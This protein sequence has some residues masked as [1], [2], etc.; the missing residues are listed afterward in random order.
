MIDAYRELFLKPHTTTFTMAG[1]IARIALPMSSIGII[2]MIS[3]LYDSYALAGL[4]SATFVLTYALISPQVSRLV[5]R[6]GQRDILPIVTIICTVGFV[7]LIYSAWKQTGNWCLFIGAFLA[8][9]MPSISAMVRA[10]WT[11]LYRDHP[12]LQSAYSLE[13][14]LDEVSFI[15]G[16]P[17]SVGLSIILFPQASLI[18]AILLLI[19][20]VIIL[21]LQRATE[22]QLDDLNTHLPNSGSIIQLANIRLLT[23]L[24]LSMGVIVGTVDIVSVAFAEAVSQPAAASLVL[25]AYALGSCISGL[26][27]GAL[28][29]SMPLHRLLL[30]GGI[31]TAIATIPLAWIN[32]IAILTCVVF[33]AGIFFA[34][35]MIVA[36]SLVERLVPKHRLT[37]AM[38][39]LLA[40]LN[41]GVALGAASAG[42]M[43]DRYGLQYGFLIAL[44]AGAIIFILALF[45][46]YRLRHHEQSSA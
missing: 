16:P 28:K 30:F 26:W 25:S 7:I 41:I 27:F 2:L 44:G 17:L 34:P 3:Q 14:V 11:E 29:L 8:G 42:Q 43:L 40:G 31:A 9:F 12:R 46:N 35:T 21:V 15:I 4:V 18:V 23:L 22:P 33:V 20:G 32:S 10:R 13:T 19:I 38:T 5:D 24:M 37:E 6:Y 36:M 45:G 1:L 39:W